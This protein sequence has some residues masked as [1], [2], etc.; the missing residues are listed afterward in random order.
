MKDRRIADSFYPSDTRGSLARSFR[1]RRSCI[2][3]YPIS[4]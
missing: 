2:S 4:D 1:T 3:H